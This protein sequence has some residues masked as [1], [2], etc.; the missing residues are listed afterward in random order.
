MR[1]CL[2]CVHQAEDVS[3]LLL[4]IKQR[5]PTID[6]SPHIETCKIC[7]SRILLCIS[8]KSGSEKLK[9]DCNACQNKTFWNINFMTH[10]IEL[11]LFSLSIHNLWYT[12]P[13]LSASAIMYSSVQQ[14][15]CENG[16][17][18]GMDFTKL[19]LSFIGQP[20][21]GTKRLCSSQRNKIKKKS[22]AN[23]VGEEPEQICW[24]TDPVCTCTCVYVC[25]HTERC[26]QTLLLCQTSQC[27]RCV[28]CGAVA[29]A[30]HTDG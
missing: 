10:L 19:P 20:F 5:Y 6:C 3:R 1:K 16:H 30:K 7:H 28:C 13:W 26:A 17:N 2:G 8:Q 23:D 9:N 24:C 12:S 29:V 25:V 4:Q 11:S 18:F 15:G 21:S 22:W 27:R 14:D